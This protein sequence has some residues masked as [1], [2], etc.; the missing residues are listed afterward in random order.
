MTQ[1][2]K[3]LPPQF[4][5]GTSKL[6]ATLVIASFGSS[7]GYNSQAFTLNVLPD[8]NTPP[9]ATQKALRYG[10]LEEIHHVFRG[11]PKS[12]NILISTVFGLG[13]IAALPLLVGAVSVFHSSF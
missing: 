1:T 5:R 8:P 12:P 2:Y 3:D 11:D 4:L 7:S 13:S 10:K 6:T 9:A